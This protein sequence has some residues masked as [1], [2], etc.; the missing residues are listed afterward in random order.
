MYS[1]EGAVH[2][3]NHH[4]RVLLRLVTEAVTVHHLL[5]AAEDALAE[6]LGH[7]GADLAGRAARHRREEAKL[8]LLLKVAVNPSHVQVKLVDDVV[9]RIEVVLVVLL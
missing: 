6:R 5:G 1:N 7:E 9:L 2:A 3:E 4:H 8:W